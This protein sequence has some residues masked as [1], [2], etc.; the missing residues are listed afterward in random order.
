[1]LDRHAGIKRLRFR[2]LITQ[3]RGST[4]LGELTVAVGAK[5]KP[6]L[7]KLSGELCSRRPHH[8]MTQATMRLSLVLDWI[9]ARTDFD[10]FTIAD[11]ED[12]QHAFEDIGSDDSQP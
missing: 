5:R 9:V 3:N 4:Q 8:R 1:M 2:A 6:P 7:Y 10:G 11:I 12:L